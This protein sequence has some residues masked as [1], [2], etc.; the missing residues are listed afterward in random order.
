[1]KNLPLIDIAAARPVFPGVLDVTAA[2][3]MCAAGMLGKNI[4]YF[5]G[6]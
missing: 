5:S 1:M 3:M 6:I 2:A 4:F